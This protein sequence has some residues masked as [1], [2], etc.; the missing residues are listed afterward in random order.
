MLKSDDIFNIDEVISKVENA[1][2][3]DRIVTGEGFSEAM[4]IREF[5]ARH[6]KSD[7]KYADIR[8]YEGNAYL[9]ID[10]GSTTTKWC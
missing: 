7:L 3:T 4:R 6:S 5:I 10:A 8:T 9:G 2:A 1:T